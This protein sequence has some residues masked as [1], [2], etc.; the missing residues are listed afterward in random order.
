MQLNKDAAKKLIIAELGG[1]NN[2]NAQSMR[3]FF[4][5]SI[6]NI[7]SHII[8]MKDKTKYHQRREQKIPIPLLFLKRNKNINLF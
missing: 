6:P 5:F 2:I 4:F 3:N 7:F 8:K 1:M